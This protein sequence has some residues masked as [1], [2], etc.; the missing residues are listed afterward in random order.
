LELAT[1]LGHR[2][3][4]GDGRLDL[5]VSIIDPAVSLSLLTGN[6]DGTF[7]APVNFDNPSH[8]DSPAIVATDLDNDGRHG[9]AGVSVFRFLMQK[10]A[11]V[12]G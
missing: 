3:Q 6:G 1:T 8:V 5:V 4:N 2:N 9:N 7:N 10:P 11:S 12:S